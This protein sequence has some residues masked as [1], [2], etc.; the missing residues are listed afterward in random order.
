MSNACGR[1]AINARLKTLFDGPRSALAANRSKFVRDF[2]VAPFYG[3]NRERAALQ[4]VVI[5]NWW[6]QGSI[7]AAKAHSGGIKAFLKRTRP[8]ISVDIGLHFGT[9]R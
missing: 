2:P 9:A 4:E 6:W 3:F 8:K 1:V 7:G 5:Q